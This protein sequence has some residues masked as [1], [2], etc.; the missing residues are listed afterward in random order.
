MKKM[1]AELSW[2]QD[3]QRGMDVTLQVLDKD[4]TALETEGAHSLFF[5]LIQC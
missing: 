2:C 1:H 4:L 3:Q 5:A